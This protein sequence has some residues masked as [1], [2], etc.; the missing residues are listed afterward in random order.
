MS[1]YRTIGRTKSR[2][3]QIVTADR[4]RY[5]NPVAYGIPEFL[6][7]VYPPFFERHPELSSLGGN[8]N[9]INTFTGVCVILRKRGLTC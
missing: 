2:R 8:T 7:E 4:Y 5:Q 3:S 6:T 9:G 1:R